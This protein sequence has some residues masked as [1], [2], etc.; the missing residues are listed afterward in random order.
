MIRFYWLTAAV[1]LALTVA[2]LIGAIT[3]SLGYLLWAAIGVFLF[4]SLVRV[5]IKNPKS[6][7]L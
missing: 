6:L 4:T 3:K 2:A 5:L 1:I 7:I